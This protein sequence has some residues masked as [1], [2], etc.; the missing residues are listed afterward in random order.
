MPGMTDFLWKL[1]NA[2]FIVTIVYLCVD[3]GA[4]HGFI[5]G[6]MAFLGTMFALFSGSGL[7]AIFIID[8]N[9]NVRKTALL[10]SLI[11]L[12][13]G[14]YMLTYS[15]LH[16]TLFNFQITPLSWAFMTF[17]IAF[18]ITRNEASVD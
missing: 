9:N 13:I 3:A 8:Q 16:P 10:I 5:K 7:R 6:V 1:I 17:A 12:A 11:M 15:Q 18:L 4:T 2:A 14:C